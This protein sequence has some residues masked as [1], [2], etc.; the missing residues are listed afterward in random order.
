MPFSPAPGRSTWPAGMMVIGLYV[1]GR[2]KFI[3]YPFWVVLFPSHSTHKAM[4]TPNP[5]VGQFMAKI[6]EELQS[7]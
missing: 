5:E 1:A 4:A 6:G 2:F 3:G 7:C